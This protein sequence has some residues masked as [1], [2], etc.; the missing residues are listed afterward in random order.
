[1]PFVSEKNPYLQPC[2]IGVIPLED[3]QALVLVA[4][5]LN[6]LFGAI[7]IFDDSYNSVDVPLRVVVVVGKDTFCSRSCGMLG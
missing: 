7:E 6:V 3:K 2:M 5:G 1:M 4:M